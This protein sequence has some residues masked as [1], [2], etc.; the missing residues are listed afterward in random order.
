MDDVF[1]QRYEHVRADQGF[2]KE[3][4]AP[5]RDASTY[6]LAIFCQKVHEKSGLRRE[7]ASQ[8]RPLG[9]TTACN[10]QLDSKGV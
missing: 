8:A 1:S 6:H 2:P 7:H 4:P 5:V 9:S 3:T 10:K